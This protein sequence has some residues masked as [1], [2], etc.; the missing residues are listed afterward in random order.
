M[1]V[2]T[3]GQQLSRLIGVV[4]RDAFVGIVVRLFGRRGPAG[5]GFR[6]MR[7]VWRPP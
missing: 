2:L 1:W 4:V 7:A 5:E 3:T 6:E